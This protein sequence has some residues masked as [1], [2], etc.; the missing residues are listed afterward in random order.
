MGLRWE[1]T[2]SLEEAD[3]IMCG[4][5]MP[6]EMETCL[7]D[8]KHVMRVYKNLWPSLRDFWLAS[9]KQNSQNIYVVLGNVRL[10]Y[11]Q[12]HD[13]AIKVAA[14]FRNV[15][16]IRKG[17]RVCIASRN[18]PEYLMVFW[19]CHMLGAITVLAN[20]W[21]PAQPLHHCIINTQC[22][23]LVL[24][25]ER[26]DRL[27]SDIISLR[28]RAGSTG[29]LV[30]DH[31]RKSW[32]A[33]DSLNS[34]VDTWNPDGASQTRQEI[35][36]QV[37][38]IRPEDNATIIFTG[39]T[40]LPKGV[41]STNR[42]FL[43]NVINVSAAGIR[44]S[45]RRG[46]GLPSSPTGPQKGVLLSAPLFHVTG[47][48]S[49]SMVATMNGFKIIMMHK[50]NPEDAARL[51]KTENVA[52]AG[53]V[54]AM[55]ADLVRS[56]LVGFPLEG[57]LFGGSS[58][59]DSLADRAKEAFPGAIMS[60]AYGL[61]ETNSV[62]VAISGDDYLSRPSSTGRPCPVNDV[63]IMHGDRM[64]DAGTTG[65]VWLR[66]PNVMKGYWNDSDATAKIITSDGWLK[67]GDLGY[68][69][70]EGFL[71]IKDR[72]KD[73]IL[74][75]GENIDSVSVENALY[76]DSRVIEAAAVGVPDERLGELV[77]A[78]VY[79]KPESRGEVTEET[80][81]ALAQ[82]RLPG[83]AVPV[84]IKLVDKPFELTPSGKIMKAGLRNLARKIWEERKAVMRGA[85]L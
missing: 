57:L 46:H 70:T 20:A 78:V 13:K 45:L 27:E 15:Y 39:T 76:S 81:I 49:Y 54:P 1:P 58:S 17:D 12:V 64:V 10:T 23:L 85:K 43:T 26:A 22:K 50:W 66:G 11:G 24:D 5:G 59:P 63:M 62:A 52:I 60:Q 44:A 55:V 31:T 34:V 71:Y 48:T 47:L 61:T 77:A 67:S 28:Q 72:L 19:A 82:T 32:N 79:V 51:I 29:V 4:P 41:L 68:L 53:G 35:L 56:S 69:D 75:G 33:M 84:M 2:L 18:C 3:A 40:G 80:L 16:D 38:D 30:F 6:H 73:V 14:V 65:E 36:E 83:F 25:H 74:R 7:V 42:Q 21:L 9:V 8:G 37:T